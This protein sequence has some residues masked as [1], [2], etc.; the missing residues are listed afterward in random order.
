MFL[1]RSNWSRIVVECTGATL[2]FL[3]VSVLVAW[4]FDFTPLIQV[5]PGMPPMHRTSALGF[6][7]AGI[8]LILIDTGQRQAA[9]FFAVAMLIPAVLVALEYLLNL[10]FGVDQLLGPDYISPS[11]SHVGRLS[12]FTTF[13][14]LAGALSLLAMSSA[15]LARRTSGIVGIASSVLIA[16][17]SVP[18]LAHLGHAQAYGWGYFSWIAIHTGLGHALLGAGLLALAWQEWTGEGLPRWIAPSVGLGIGVAALGVWQGLLTHQESTLPVLS[19]IVLVGG[20]LLGGLLAVAISQTQRSRSRGRDLQ[21]EKA[22]LERL[23]EAVPDGLLVTDKEGRIIRANQRVERVF[24]CTRADLLGQSMETFVPVRL[25]ELDGIREVY[26]LHPTSQFSLH[27]RRKDSSEFPV[28]VSLGQLQS[29]NEIQILMVVRDVSERKQAEEAL[30]QS[31]ERFRGVFEMSPLGLALIQ[32][33]YRLAKVNPS[34]CRMSGYSEVELVGMNPFDITHPDDREMSMGL[35]ERLFRGEIP[36]YQ[37]EKRYMKKD[38]EIIW[39]NLTATILRD[40]EGRPLV[41]LGMIQDITERKH[42]EAKLEANREQ[43]VASARLSALGMMA[44]GV[45][46]E[47][48]NPI[49]IIHAMASD[50]EEMVEEEGSVPP[51]VVARKS[52]IIRETA[53]RIAR[54]VK[55]MRQI[56]REGAGDPFRSARLSKILG[57]TLEICRARF[58]ANE[59]KL[60]I[61]Q[62]IPELNVF[63][64]EVQI[65]Q[66]LLNLLQ[67]AL[68][69]VMEQKGERWV[70]LEVFDRG[71]SVSIAV[72]DSGPGIQPEHRSRI[73]EPF[74]TTKDVGKG[75]GLGLSLS[76]TIAE[77]HGGKLECSEDHGHT[78]FSLLLP[79]A[80]TVEAA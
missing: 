21:E 51:Q 50:L 8:A 77:E 47:I 26:H 25:R 42:M 23:F 65:E 20:F 22:N 68:D 52:A 18:A 29:G 60:L 44:G 79:L 49:S 63:C 9:R 40:R 43:M 19:G 11:I 48:N 45:A 38:G 33:D 6:L 37:V 66:A 59:V 46:H 41:G 69:A 55:A 67:N 35:A 32:P 16:I 3:G 75:V 34:L 39:G 24:G 62:D 71:D 57:E 5:L 1:R 64:R 10:D 27:A 54:I 70:K 15:T 30:R 31:E 74:F 12:P 72:I 53:E 76:K 78:R 58:K 61:P 4:H 2:S 14:F 7:L 28:D 17:G 56:S 73:M 13:C 80:R 36:F